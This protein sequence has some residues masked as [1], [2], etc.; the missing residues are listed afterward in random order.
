M[1]LITLKLHERE[2]RKELRGKGKIRQAGG[3]G[4]EERKRRRRRG[5]EYSKDRKESRG[6]AG[7]GGHEN[8]SK[9]TLPNIKDSK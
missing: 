2:E 8:D 7:G 1:I 9:H 5:T 3:E 4:V 6:D